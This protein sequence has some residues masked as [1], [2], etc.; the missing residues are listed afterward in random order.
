MSGVVVQDGRVVLGTCGELTV[1]GDSRR[2]HGFIL[3]VGEDIAG[4]VTAVS[5][6]E[7][8]LESHVEEI[9]LESQ[10][11]IVVRRTVDL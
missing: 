10:R 4:G 2:V 8:D 1:L 7:R 11:V 3:G 5:A 6:F 9:F